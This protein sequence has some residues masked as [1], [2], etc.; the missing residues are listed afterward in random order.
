M[1]TVGATTSAG[2]GADAPVWLDDIFTLGRPRDREDV[3]P[4]PKIDPGCPVIVAG[5]IQLSEQ[6]V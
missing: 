4:E 1:L 2:G 3:W 6:G 5:T